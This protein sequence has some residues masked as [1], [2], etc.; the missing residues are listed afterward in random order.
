MCSRQEIR[1]AFASPVVECE[2][3]GSNVVE[4]FG[5][6]DRKKLSI[7]CIVCCVVKFVVI[8]VQLSVV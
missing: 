5:V 8:S 1:T 7:V 6:N 2:E 4:F 3:V